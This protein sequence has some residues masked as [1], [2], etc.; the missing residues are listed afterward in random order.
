MYNTNINHKL[1]L[2]ICELCL[3]PCNTLHFNLILD[4]FFS[5]I[6]EAKTKRETKKKKK[7]MWFPYKK[8]YFDAL[9]FNLRNNIYNNEFL[10]IK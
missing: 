4:F 10:F 8:H 1:S 3:I 2:C 9:T 5:Q 6:K 7:R